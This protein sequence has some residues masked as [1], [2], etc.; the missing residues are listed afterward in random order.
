M[1]LRD[2][3]A[4]GV[5]VGVAGVAVIT[6][7][8]WPKGGHPVAVAEPPPTAP[9]VPASAAAAEALFIRVHKARTLKDAYVASSVQMTDHMNNTSDGTLLFLFW[10]SEH[11]KFPDVVIE[12]DETTF[13]LVRKDIGQER[14]KR[15]CIGGKVI[16][17]QADSAGASK[18]YAGIM[19][20]IDEDLTVVTAPHHFYAVGST[21]D[22]VGGSLARLCG[23]VTGLYDYSSSGG[24]VG[25]GIE[26]VGVFDLKEN[27]GRL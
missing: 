11:A 18:W 8:M 6:A 21:R 25:H 3:I 17:I 9:D 22:I 7:V 1:K 12:H 26:I 4:I 14:G 15:M 23:V 19:L 5:G 10:M 20:P 2:W 16:E 27:G 13:P 24:G